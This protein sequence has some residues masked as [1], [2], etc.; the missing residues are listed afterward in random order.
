MELGPL[1][2][3]LVGLDGFELLG[4]N[5]VEPMGLKE[6]EPLSGTV[7]AG[8]IGFNA[9][10]LNAAVGVVVTGETHWQGLL[11][12]DHCSNDVLCVGVLSGILMAPVCLNGWLLRQAR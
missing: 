4:L 7:Y 11:L 6:L 8:S 2:L 10:G 5:V 9:S 1:S 3:L 12:S